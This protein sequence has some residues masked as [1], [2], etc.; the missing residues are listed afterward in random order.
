MSP[1]WAD[2]VSRCAISARIWSLTAPVPAS[3]TLFVRGSEMTWI[4]GAPPTA[5]AA[6]VQLAQH[7]HDVVGGSVLELD[8]LDVLRAG[9]VHAPNELQH[10]AHVLRPVGDDQ[11]VRARVRREMR[12]LRQERP[13]DRHELRGADVVEDDRLSDV[14]VAGAETSVRVRDDLNRV[15][16]V[17]RDEPV[18]LERRRGTSDRTRRPSSARSK[19]RS[20]ARAREGR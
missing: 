13:Q 9:L 19:A 15:A 16:R 2:G 4:G 10:A 20:A 7:P 12:R 17:E 1:P 8:D 14:V 11:R 18:D 3:S 6:C 5:C